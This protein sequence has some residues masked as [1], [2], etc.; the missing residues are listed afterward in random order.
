VVLQIIDLIVQYMEV[1]GRKMVKQ[2]FQAL[3]NVKPTDAVIKNKS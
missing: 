1:S 3:R 2:N